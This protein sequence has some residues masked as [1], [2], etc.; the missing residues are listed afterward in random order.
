MDSRAPEF[1]HGCP[2]KP[3]STSTL[4]TLAE[5]ESDDSV[6]RQIA[7][8]VKCARVAV[9][10]R[11]RDLGGKSQPFSVAKQSRGGGARVA[12]PTRPLT[13]ADKILIRKPQL[14]AKFS[15]TLCDQLGRDIES[16]AGRC[17][18]AA[19]S[20]RVPSLVTCAV[21]TLSV[22]SANR[23]QPELP[24]VRPGHALEPSARRG[25]QMA[26]SPT[27]KAD[28]PAPKQVCARQCKDDPCR[29]PPERRPPGVIRRW[30]IPAEQRPS[31]AQGTG[32]PSS[33]RCRDQGA[34]WV[35]E[36][37]VGHRGTAALGCFGRAEHDTVCR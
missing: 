37:P 15:V 4:A 7:P 29:H 20:C 19:A 25:K 13:A 2:A 26:P 22:P 28:R 23:V 35:A 34:N 32:L 21:T 1:Q 36:P 17:R 24:G 16:S 6:F 5:A 30:A 33:R 9:V 14:T 10:A 12:R 31:A 18:A 3:G 11:R 8:V 27:M